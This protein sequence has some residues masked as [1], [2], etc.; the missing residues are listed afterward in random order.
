MID[1]DIAGHG[2]GDFSTFR[3]HMARETAVLVDNNALGC[4]T[5]VERA[6]H[7]DTFGVSDLA[8]KDGIFADD[9]DAVVV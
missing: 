3:F 9:Q 1:A 5:A 4:N 6:A 2:A 8:F 7:F